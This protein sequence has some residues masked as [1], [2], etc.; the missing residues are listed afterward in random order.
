MLSKCMFSYEAFVHGGVLL[1]SFNGNSPIYLF[2]N[3]LL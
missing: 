2:V 3:K 1:V